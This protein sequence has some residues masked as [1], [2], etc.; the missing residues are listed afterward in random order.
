ME[1]IGAAGDATSRATGPPSRRLQGERGAGFRRGLG[2][3]K[4]DTW[5]SRAYDPG[6]HGRGCCSFGSLPATPVTG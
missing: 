1:R 3:A 6:P 2:S 4:I 5:D